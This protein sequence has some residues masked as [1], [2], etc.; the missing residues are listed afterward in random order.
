MK[1]AIDAGNTSVF[2]AFYKKEEIVETLRFKTTDNLYERL[3]ELNFKPKEVIISS[4][5]L[6]IN[7]ELRNACLE[8]LECEPD[9]VSYFSNHG[10][11][12]KIENAEMMG[13]DLIA[14]ACGGVSLYKNKNLIIF[15]LGTTT[16]TSVI[17]KNKEFVG[18]NIMPGL[19]TSLKS[20][21]SNCVLLQDVEF[22]ENKINLI[23]NKTSNCM[24]SGAFHAQ[25]GAMTHIKN[26]IKKEFFNGDAVVIATGGYAKLFEKYGIFDYIHETLVTD[27]IIKMQSEQKEKVKETV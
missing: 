9:F 7:N 13:S 19:M 26:Q 15:D 11:D 16:T 18:G 14:A 8:V 24:I 27:G 21:S 10:L 25:L 12:I 20:L 3:K 22:D 23:G 17:T 2:C 6:N 1:L 4:V 5:A